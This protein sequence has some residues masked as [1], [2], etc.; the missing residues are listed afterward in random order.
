MAAHLQAL[1]D[2]VVQEA[3]AEELDGLVGVLREAQPSRGRRQGHPTT[4]LLDAVDR[5]RWALGQAAPRDRAALVI[6]AATAVLRSQ[7]PPGVDLDYLDGFVA[8]HRDHLHALV[9]GALE[10]RAAGASR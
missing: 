4:R 1:P 3:S 2:A 10:R 8:R 6:D 7:P 9:S 5:R